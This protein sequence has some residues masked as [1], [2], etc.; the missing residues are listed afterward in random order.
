M[1]TVFAILSLALIIGGC[2]ETRRNRIDASY[3]C[4]GK[5]D[6]LKFAKE[7]KPVVMRP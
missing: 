2:A 1:K 5:F 6:G 7:G 3:D 4:D